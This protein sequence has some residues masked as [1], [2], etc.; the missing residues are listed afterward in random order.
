[1][2]KDHESDIGQFSAEARSH[3]RA[4]QLARATIPTL[5]KHLQIARNIQRTEG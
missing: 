3:N 1:M 2:V 4:A 5:R